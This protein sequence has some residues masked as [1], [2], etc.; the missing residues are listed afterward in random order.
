MSTDRT[1][2]CCTSTPPIVIEGYERQ[3]TVKETAAGLKYYEIAPTGDALK[4][5]DLAIIV[6]YDIYGSESPQT[7]QQCDRVSAGLGCKVVMP[8]WFGVEGAYPG[9]HTVPGGKE[10]MWEW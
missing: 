7:L 2:D 1:E 3:G 5:K 6:I 8:F 10:A 4:Y 9:D